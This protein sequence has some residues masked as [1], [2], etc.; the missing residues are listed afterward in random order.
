MST[1]KIPDLTKNFVVVIALVFAIALGQLV[2][3]FLPSITPPGRNWLGGFLAVLVLWSVA[4]FM[5]TSER[6]KFASR[7]SVVS[8][9]C[10]ILYMTLCGILRV[11]IVSDGFYGDL[12]RYSTSILIAFASYHGVLWICRRIHTRKGAEQNVT[13]KSDRA[14]G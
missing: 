7:E 14:G 9:G 11:S 1:I 6:R 10:V 3:Y 12:I 2:A 4:Y 13:P 5:P 8:G